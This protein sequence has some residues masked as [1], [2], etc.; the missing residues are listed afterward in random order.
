MGLD[1][2]EYVLALESTFGITIPDADARRLETP[3]HVIDYLAG[4][5]PLADEPV[6]DRPCFTQ[7]AFYRARAA[8]AAR[9]AVPVKELGPGAALHPLV[10][11]RDGW[12]ALRADLG[13]YDWP[14]LHSDHWLGAHLGGVRTLGELA[15]HLALYDRAL[16]RP[17]GAPWTHQEIETVVVQLLERETGI[18]MAK[19][20][21]DSRFVKDMGL[22]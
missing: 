3:R 1:I 15:R 21:L 18:E 5:L 12:R 11:G 10:G 9:F 13:A 19:Y 8:A 17:P 6:I 7:R 2:V 20:T 16:L 4:R 14:R 22:D